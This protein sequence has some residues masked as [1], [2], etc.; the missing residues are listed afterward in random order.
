MMIT[1][2]QQPAKDW[3]A[4]HLQNFATLIESGDDPSCLVTYGGIEFEVRL[5]KLP[6]HFEREV[7]KVDAL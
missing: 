2:L 6:G 7:L 1:D 5:N 3:I 4:D